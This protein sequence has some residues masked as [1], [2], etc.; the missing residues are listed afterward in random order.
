MRFC[1]VP[2]LSVHNKL[3]LCKNA[4]QVGGETKKNECGK[5]RKIKEGLLYT[6]YTNY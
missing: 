1:R 6:N 4:S 2:N 3:R 5:I